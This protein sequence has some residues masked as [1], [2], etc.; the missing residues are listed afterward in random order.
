MDRRITVLE[1]RFDTILPT[2]ATKADLADVRLD[3]EKMRSEL[4]GKINESG[5]ELRGEIAAQGSELR[6]AIAVQG[7]ELRREMNELGTGLRAEMGKLSKEVQSQLMK[8]MMWFGAPAMTV[9]FS[10]VGFGIYLSNQVAQQVTSQIGNQIHNLSARLPVAN[11]PLAP[12]RDRPADGA[13][14]PPSR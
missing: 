6:A 2:L 5:S 11:A 9:I 10:M 8:A 1:T 13:M 7:S 3:L 12:P 14:P 4:L